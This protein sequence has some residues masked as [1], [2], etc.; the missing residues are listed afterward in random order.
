MV[1]FSSGCGQDAKSA[2]GSPREQCRDFVNAFCDKESECSPPS[3]RSRTKK[4]CEF[5]L[6][7]DFPCE[8]ISQV[9]GQIGPCLTEIASFDCQTYEELQYVPVPDSCN[10]FYG[11]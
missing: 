7:L 5:Q 6:A 2:P 9:Q 8:D 10:I 11:P 4:D 3:D 1:L